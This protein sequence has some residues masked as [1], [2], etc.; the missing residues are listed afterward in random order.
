MDG[1]ELKRRYKRNHEKHEK[2]ERIYLCGEKINL[3]KAPTGRDIIAPG[4]ARGLEV[5]KKTKAL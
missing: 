2:H 1:I 3:I 5:T 4:I